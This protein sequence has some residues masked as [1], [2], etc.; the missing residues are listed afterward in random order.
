MNATT[1]LF[2]KSHFARDF[3]QNSGLFKSDKLVG[4]G[5]ALEK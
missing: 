2:V 1:Q 4:N 5:S 3:L